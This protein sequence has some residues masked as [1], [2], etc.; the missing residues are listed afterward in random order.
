MKTRFVFKYQNCKTNVIQVFGFLMEFEWH[1]L[2]NEQQGLAKKFMI[3]EVLPYAYNR[4]RVFST[5]LMSK[6][7]QPSQQC[8]RFLYYYSE[9]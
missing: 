1:E 4:L 8:F 6:C 9:F 2:L 7:T 3:F 5:L